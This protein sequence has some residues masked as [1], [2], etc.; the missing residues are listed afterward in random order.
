VLRPVWPGNMKISSLFKIVTQP[1]FNKDYYYYYIIIG[2]TL[3]SRLKLIETGSE[4]FGR[5]VKIKL[6]FLIEFL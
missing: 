3:K 2:W 6:I 1:K 4:F 5:C